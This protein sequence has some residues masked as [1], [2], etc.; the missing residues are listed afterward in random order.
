MSTLAE[1]RELYMS[2]LSTRQVAART[3]WSKSRVAVH[4]ADIA[5][6]QSTAAILRQP[7]KSKHWRS[8]RQAARKVW[9]RARGPIPRDY[10][11]HHINGDHTDNRIENLEILSPTVHAHRHRPPNLVPKWKRPHVREYMRKYLRDYYWRR[12]NA[13]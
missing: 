3:D 4:V 11:V 13:S 5:R 1:V 12:K 6:D 7:P 8:S 2:G 9:I 10:H